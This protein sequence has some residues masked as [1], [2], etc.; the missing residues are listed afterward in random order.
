MAKKIETTGTDKPQ[1]LIE[2]EERLEKENEALHEAALQDA[3]DEYKATEAE[4]EAEYQAEQEAKLGRLMAFRKKYRAKHFS[5][6]DVGKGVIASGI[7]VSLRKIAGDIA[8]DTPETLYTQAETSAMKG[9]I[10][11]KAEAAM[12]EAYSALSSWINANYASALAQRTILIESRDSLYNSISTALS[13]EMVKRAIKYELVLDGLSKQQRI[14]DLHMANIDFRHLCTQSSTFF[15]QESRIRKNLSYALRYL[16]LYD[17]ALDILASETG[18]R[19]LSVYQ[20]GRDTKYHDDHSEIVGKLED[21][22]DLME[23]LKVHVRNSPEYASGPKSAYYLHEMEERLQPVEVEAPPI[24][25]Q[26][27]IQAAGMVSQLRLFKDRTTNMG[28]LLYALSMD[29]L[30]G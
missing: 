5:G 27:L 2:Q 10:T 3:V 4:L 12:F 30:G 20:M 11:L 21:L 7:Y 22:N 18:I 19:E 9:T 15:M 23:A 29:Y 24:P 26:N 8:E 6:P 17:T 16:N 13:G 28:Y 1:D 14:A 25:K